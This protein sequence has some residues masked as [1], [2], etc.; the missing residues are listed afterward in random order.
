MGS[1][2]S[3]PKAPPPTQVV[4]VPAAEP[5]EAEGPNTEELA[6]EQ[7]EASLLSRQRGHLGTIATSF[8]GFL[9][10]S[11]SASTRKTLLGE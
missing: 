7:R 3:S 2:T 1:L 4:H 8:R 5:V 11:D 6:A 10:E 9:G